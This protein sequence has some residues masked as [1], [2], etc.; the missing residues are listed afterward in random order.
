M[1]FGQLSHRESLSDLILYLQSEQNKSYHLGMSKGI[2]KANLA[3]ENENRDFRIYESFAL[4]L[5]T[6]VQKLAIPNTILDLSIDTPVY[7]L[8]A[9]V[10]DLCLE[11]FWWGC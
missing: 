7:T 1:I 4:I 6:Q 8:N 2:S 10:I 11:V 5:V 9:T 3:K